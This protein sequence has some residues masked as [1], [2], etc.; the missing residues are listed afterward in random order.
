V[1]HATNYNGVR[2]VY[3]KLLH[4]SIVGESVANVRI[5]INAG[6]EM[7]LRKELILAVE[8]YAAALD[9]QLN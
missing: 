9:R 2:C 5:R 7:D 6:W 8:E 3:D 1:K 4:C